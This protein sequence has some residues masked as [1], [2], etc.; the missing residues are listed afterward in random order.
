[1][2][3]RYALLISVVLCVPGV[4][5]AQLKPAAAD[6]SP[7]CTRVN[8]LDTI[9]QQIELTRTYDN[10]VR[11]ITVL[12]R[13]ADL[14]WSYQQSNAR[15]AFLEAF[16]LAEQREKRNEEMNG[17]RPLAVRLQSPDQRYVVVRAV[18]K[19]DAAW[20][21]ELVTQMLKADE[22]E[23]ST[24]KERLDD[25][26]IAYRLLDSASTLIPV[27]DTAALYLARVSLKYPASSA[28]IR[29]L[30]RLAET[31]QLAAD[32]LYV[33]ALA[34]Y[35]DKPL[36]Q[37]LYLQ[38]YPFAWRESFNT[39]MYAN[40]VVPAK[41]AIDQSLQRR[42]MQV[43][44]RRAQQAIDSPLD[45][46]DVYRSSKIELLPATV[47]LLNGLVRVEPQVRE[48]LPDLLPS[49]TQARERLLVSLSADTQKLLL[50][51]GREVAT[52]P[53]QTFDE[54]I[55]IAQKNSDV[56]ERDQL[57]FSAVLSSV[58]NSENTSHV[59]Q[60]IEQ[61]SYA[62]LRERL[63]EWFYFQRTTRAIEDKQF[64]QAELLAKK[65]EGNQQR[66]YLYV[67]LAR[68]LLRRTDTQI[69]AR[70]F[71]EAAIEQARKSATSLFSARTLFTAAVLYAR[72]DLSRSIALLTEAINYTNR[73]DAPDFIKDDQTLE[74]GAVRKSSSG[75][76]RGEYEIR[77]Y[78][79]G[80][81]PQTAFRE[82]AQ[83]DFDTVVSQTN[84]ITD[85]FQRSLATLSVSEVCL[86][87]TQQ[88]AKS[89]RPH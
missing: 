46:S 29:F 73:L 31:N 77:F 2:R 36:R 78:I 12:I 65:V 42:F 6:K 28:L 81:D 79:P 82:M 7:L 8:A 57:I 17:P 20:A 27:N 18:A 55:E 84:T 76:Y 33:Q 25:E 58:S 74:T 53:Q 83:I 11:R 45:E 60:A 10:Q 24:R 14:L 13:A 1:M 86:Q 32:S 87:Q 59:V 19:R 48:L 67:E 4:A 30:Y 63:L 80:L 26:L 72:I 3:V 75:E 69:R 51:R 66:A 54:Q 49:L 41:F 34:A 40:Y 23:A 15:A 61:I 64:D 47:H 89:G 88:P 39:P 21:R 44:L 35:G 43:L 22:A 9:R 56:N 62:D 38:A 37:F 50:E 68:A 52:Q 16:E 70:E 5:F 71:L 85:K